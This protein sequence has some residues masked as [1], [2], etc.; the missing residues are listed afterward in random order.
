MQTNWIGKSYGCGQLSASRHLL[1]FRSA[2]FGYYDLLRKAGV[3]VEFKDVPL[4]A[5]RI[6]SRVLGWTPDE[7]EIDAP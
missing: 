4:H 6:M 5:E 2:T 7:G 3:E 1:L